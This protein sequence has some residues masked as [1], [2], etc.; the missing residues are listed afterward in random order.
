MG[1]CISPENRFSLNFLKNWCRYS[2]VLID[3]HL[4]WNHNIAYIINKT[5]Y[6]LFI[7]SKLSNILN[8]KILLIYY[9]KSTMPFSTVLQL[10]TLLHWE[11][12]TITINLLTFLQKR[13]LKIILKDN[14]RNLLSITLKQSVKQIFIIFKQK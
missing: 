11:E 10:M 3:N 8:Q 2:Y 6:M 4:N 13:I 12:L 5:R 1:I 9:S 7:F 14:E